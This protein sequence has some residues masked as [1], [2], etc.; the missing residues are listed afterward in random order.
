M[1]D[2]KGIKG[3]KIR[4][5]AGNP[6]NPKAGE[7][8]FNSSTNTFKTHG[9]LSAATKAWGS[10]GNLTT[11]RSGNKGCSNGSH[12]DANTYGGGGG[13]ANNTEEYNGTSW[14]S[15]GNLNT[16][17]TQNTGSGGASDTRACA[18][19]SSGNSNVC[20][21]Y[22]GSTWTTSVA[23][24]T[25]RG[26]PFADGT[27]NSITL[28]GGSGAPTGT[29]EWDGTS[30]TAA[31]VM[32]TGKTHGACCGTDRNSFMV[33]SGVEPGPSY[34]TSTCQKYDGTSW[35]TTNATTK[36]TDNYYGKACGTTADAIHFGNE[37]NLVNPGAGSNTTEE[38]DGT[39]WS[40]NSAT[41]SAA[42][43]TSNGGASG[44]AGNGLS[45][46]GYSGIDTAQQTT[47]EYTRTPAA[48]ST[49]TITTS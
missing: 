17:M 7:V 27:Q 29:E 47:E 28:S 23:C 40:A 6:A 38:W 30:W 46:G 37:Q 33:V 10:G 42:G 5:I 14:G 4:T 32:N 49:K 41:L 3:W 2:Y 34:N 12:L 45:I 36:S 20:E 35:V 44:D 24:L 19:D 11:G 13:A 9:V 48:A 1:T 8:W 43:G 16:P 25:A 15:G 21:T 31:Q 18:G 39:C 22:N 26:A